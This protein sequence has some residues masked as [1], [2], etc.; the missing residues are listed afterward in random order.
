M[1]K[2]IM[3]LV[4]AS[5]V[6]TIPLAITLQIAIKTPLKQKLNFGETEMATQY[7]AG[8][9]GGGG[10]G[11]GW[12]SSGINPLFGGLARLYN[13]GSNLY[14]AGQNVVQ[15]I[16]DSNTDTSGN[17]VGGSVPNYNTE[18]V[19]EYDQAINQTQRSMGRLGNQLRSGYSD[20]ESSYNNALN[21]LLLGK[22]RAEST[23][24]ENK[25][26]TAQNFVGAKNTIGSNAGNSLRGLQRLLGSRG[27][28]GS[29][30]ARFVAPDAVAR[31]ATI[32]RQGVTNTFG[33]N[34]KALDT[35]W[36]NYLTDYENQRTS[37]SDQRNRQRGD[38]VN[39]VRAEKANLL[40]I[41]ADL[42][43]QRAKAMGGDSVGAAKPYLEQANSI[44]DRI[45]QRRFEPIA[46]Q[47]KAYDAPELGQY[48]S[49]PT[50]P[51]FDG[52]APS[53][54]YY[55]PYLAALLANRRR[56]EQGIVA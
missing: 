37:A 15:G 51:T 29:S 32:Q 46:Y 1:Y 41:L 20:I 23:Y 35:N 19:G 43:G 45:S 28:G 4:S 36:N 7:N 26:Q 56:E 27:A 54:D 13:T 8:G 24:G 39:S 12:G 21:Q 9:G 18:L 25:Q 44:L 33:Q 34:N 55:S 30:A 14:Q 16:N 6:I 48:T 17:G 22:N 53:N 11:T 42:R 52:Q 49:T 38:L 3:I 31:E 40:Q 2:K 47:T 50:T 10:G 5:L